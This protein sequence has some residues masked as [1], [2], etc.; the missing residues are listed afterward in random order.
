M[1]PENHGTGPSQGPKRHRDPV[2]HEITLILPPCKICGHKGFETYRT[3]WRDE[4]GT[5]QS[6]ARCK[7]CGTSHIVNAI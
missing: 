6:Y 3:N 5:G 1:T 4:D 2:M 7:R